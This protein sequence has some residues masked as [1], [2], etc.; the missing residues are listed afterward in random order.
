M[1]THKVIDTL[2]HEDEGND[3]FCG[4]HQECLD[5][6]TEQEGFGYIVVPLTPD[7]IAICN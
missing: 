6:I 2:Y 3:V 5:F 4:T 7:E 1:K